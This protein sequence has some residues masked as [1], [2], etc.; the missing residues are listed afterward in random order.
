MSVKRQVQKLT[1][2][3]LSKPVKKLK[4]Y[5]SFPCFS[6][7]C[8]ISENEE[9]KQ[10]YDEGVNA[11][12]LRDSA[13]EYHVGAQSAGDL[14]LTGHALKRLAYR[15]TFTDSRADSSETHAKTCA[16]RY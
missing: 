16:E 5:L 9:Q 15:I 1:P 12:G 7:S 11:G 3:K 6:V 14:G 8:G 10:G 2:T 4:L 13:A